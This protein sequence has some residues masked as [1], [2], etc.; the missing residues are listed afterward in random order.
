MIDKATELT[1]RLKPYGPT[2]LLLLLCAVTPKSMLTSSDKWSAFLFHFTHANIWHLLAN[3]YVIA[4]FRPRWDNVPVAYLSATVAALMPFTGMSMPTVGI[5]GI[6]FALIA[7]RDAVLKIWN[8]K[9]LGINALL[10][11]VPCYNW[12]IHLAS[13]LIAFIIWKIYL[14]LTVRLRSKSA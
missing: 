2:L 12:K 14:N 9:L 11:F 6:V 5:S 8:W 1:K 4:R 10:A 3:F 13:Y 7:R